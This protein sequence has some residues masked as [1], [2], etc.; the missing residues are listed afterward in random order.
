MS[1]D[2]TVWLDP[3]PPLSHFVTILLDPPSPPRPVTY[4][5]NGP[6][7]IRGGLI[8]GGAYIRGAYIRDFTVCYVNLFTKWMLFEANNVFPGQGCDSLAN[9]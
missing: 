8:F 7:V 6:L 5:L 9:E 3:P 2:I 4:F 1:G